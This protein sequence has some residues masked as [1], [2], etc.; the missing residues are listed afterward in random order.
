MTLAA[1]KWAA[2][3]GGLGGAIGV[4]CVAAG[5]ATGPIGIAA[6][7]A[8]GMVGGAI[9]KFINKMEGKALES[10]LKLENGAVEIFIAVREG[11]KTVYVDCR[12]GG[13]I[14]CNKV[15]FLEVNLL[16]VGATGAMLATTY[17]VHQL[18]VQDRA[19]E[20]IYQPS[21]VQ[22]CWDSFGYYSKDIFEHY[23][24]HIFKHYSKYLSES[25]SNDLL[26]CY[27]L[28]PD[29][30]REPVT[31]YSYSTA[32]VVTLA[33]SVFMVLHLGYTHCRRLNRANEAS[34][35]RAKEA[36]EKAEIIRRREMEERKARERVIP[37]INIH[38][39][40]AA[41]D[42]AHRNALIAETNRINAERERDR[43]RQELERINTQQ[44]GL[45]LKWPLDW[46]TKE[47]SRFVRWIN[48]K[49]G[50]GMDINE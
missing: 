4:G 41:A 37:N 43:A 40:D 48:K 8:S 25:S 31:C 24:K 45:G 50:Q 5:L 33:G 47:N 9:A 19:C 14:L 46:P 23:S 44:E 30:M 49:F 11:V 22:A 18:S 2:A 34:I 10:A 1:G 12:G 3:G 17:A 32:K 38:D 29:T 39:A 42:A 26:N 15:Q 7:I 21:C 16:H 20:L 13:R 28:C 35:A 6:C 27:Y 36:A